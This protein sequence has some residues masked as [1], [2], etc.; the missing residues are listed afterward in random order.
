M[1]LENKLAES[2][3]WPEH[4][5]DRPILF[6]LAAGGACHLIYPFDPERPPQDADRLGQPADAYATHYRVTPRS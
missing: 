2:S 3:P 5:G 6:L 4:Q 1:D